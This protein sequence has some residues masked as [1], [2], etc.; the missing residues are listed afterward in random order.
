MKNQ[1]CGYEASC[2]TGKRLMESWI[3]RRVRAWLNEEVITEEGEPKYNQGNS[4]HLFFDLKVTLVYIV[5]RSHD[6]CFN[7]FQILFKMNIWLSMGS[8]IIIV[9]NA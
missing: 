6:I 7:L 2:K 3:L 5:W 8:S 4:E 9:M 1:E